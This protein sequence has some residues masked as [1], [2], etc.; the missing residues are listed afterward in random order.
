[1]P[2]KEIGWCQA[3]LGFLNNQFD[4]TTGAYRS[5]P[6]GRPTLYG[7]CYALLGRYYLGV[8][9]SLESSTEV[10][11]ENTQDPETG[12]LVGPELI[13][14]MAKPGAMH[15]RDHLLLH[16]T[17]AAIPTCQQFG[18]TL[19]HK[20]TAAHR[21]C[22]REY[23]ES[24][25]EAR[26]LKEAWFE[27]NNLLFVGQLLVYLRDV[28]KHP[29]A[30]S[31]L[32]LWFEWLDANLDP[33]TGLWGT[34]GFCSPAAAVYGGYHQ[35]LVYYFEN[36]RVTN[37][38][39][40]IDTVLDLQHLDGGFNPDGNAGACEDVDSVDILVNLYKR[41]DHRRADIRHALRRCVKHILSTQNADGGFPYN[42]NCPQSHMGVPGTQA[43]PNV[44]TTFPTWFRTHTLALA[45]QILPNDHEFKGLKLRFNQEL[46]M[47]WHQS[48]PGWKH[49]LTIA[50]HAADLGNVIKFRTSMATTPVRSGA[51][52]A[53][54]FAGRALHKL[55]L[56]R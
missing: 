15:D 28:E 49:S 41:L 1:M 55:G 32:D 9:Q 56:R 47:G 10:F 36:H 17:C 44:S 4:Q 8:D 35:L 51:I 31:A 27:G 30:Q 3:V 25:M 43:G 38:A 16:L 45:S 5:V 21:F 2:Q 46:C 6:G 7:T 54:R 13:D 52:R 19:R 18:V 53:R 37:P 11:I 26:D 23:L 22:D 14:F 33:E 24:W 50:D 34:N 29:G 48:P 12:L 20:I 42:R 40:M 39:G